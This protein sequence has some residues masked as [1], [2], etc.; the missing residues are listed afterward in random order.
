MALGRGLGRT[1]CIH[2]GIWHG[3]GI[4]G[5]SSLFVYHQRRERRGRWGATAR[6][7][8]AVAR[9][10]LGAG[11]ELTELQGGAEQDAAFE[12]GKSESTWNWAASGAQV[13]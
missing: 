1:S 12:D 5:L 2:D 10:S 9:S 4:F 11:G 8:V 6:Q 7:R 3:V 13:F